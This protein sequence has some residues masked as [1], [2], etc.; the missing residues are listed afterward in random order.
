MNYPSVSRVKTSDL[1]P[2]DWN[3]RT[4]TD[5]ALGRLTRSLSEFGNL[6]PITVNARTGNVIAGHQ[7][8]KC[9][10]AMNVAETDCW[11]V[12][13]PAEKEKAANLTL[14]NLAGEWDYVRLE[15]VLAELQELG[16]DL[17]L[18]GFPA[19]RI[20]EIL[21]G[22]D[23]IPPDAFPAVEEN[24]PIEHRCPK[25]GYEWSGKPRG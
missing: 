22:I 20:D 13:L 1:K 21:G 8:L 12:D 15:T 11:L 17:S 6:Q 19:A 10:L 18:T 14:N 7:R 3:P 4:I 25:C 24:L 9:L 2:A 23:A 16:G 5:E